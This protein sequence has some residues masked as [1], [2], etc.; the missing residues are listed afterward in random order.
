M[1]GEDGL[2]GKERVTDTGD[3]EMMLEI[4]GHIFRFEAFEMAAGH[5]SGSHGLGGVIFEFIEQ[6]VLSGEDYSEKRLG[7][8]LELGDGL[9]LGQ[10]IIPKE[11][12]LVDDEHGHLLALCG[13]HD[14]RPDGF[15]VC[16]VKQKS[17]KKSC[18]IP[19]E[20]MGKF[21]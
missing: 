4:S 18:K 1:D 19:H 16:F 15:D 11:T 5:D 3:L 8:E 14:L 2:I 10:D 21:L 17:P 7:I 20:V 12:G 13:I 6:I 9:Y